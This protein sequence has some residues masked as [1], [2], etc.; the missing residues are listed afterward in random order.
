V[1][2][3][4]RGANTHIVLGS[5]NATNAALL[6]PTNVEI[7]AELVGRRSQVGGIDK[8]LA[9]EGLGE[10]LVE[11]L[12]P[13]EMPKGDDNRRAAEMSLEAARNVI[14]AAQLKIVCKKVED[15]TWSLSLRGELPIFDGIFRACCWPI[16]MSPES[17]VELGPLTP[18]Q[19]VELGVFGAAAIT[20]LLAIE[21]QASAYKMNIRFVL[22]LPLEGLPEERQTA[23]MQT[24]VRNWEGFVRYLL[25]LLGEMEQRPTPP[26]GEEEQR[27]SPWHFTGNDTL[28]L[29]EELVRAYS[30]KPERLQDVANVVGNSSM[31]SSPICL[32][33]CKNPKTKCCGNTCSRSTRRL[34]PH[35][36][37]SAFCLPIPWTRASGACCGCRPPCPIHS[38]PVITPRSVT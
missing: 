12:A 15:S 8:L 35:A 20:G 19:N 7:L 29:L 26:G 37:A 36:H 21:L 28:P 2:L 22:N 13:E 14:A 9:P 23:I 27:H 18:T 30:R 31:P 32:R 1:Y 25:L 38:P 16:T 6:N 11:Y 17:A 33:C 10:V 34:I 4:E 3:F 5:A 24:V